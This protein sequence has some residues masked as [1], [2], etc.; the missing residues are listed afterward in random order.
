[1][2]NEEVINNVNAVVACKNRQFGSRDIVVIGGGAVGCETA[3]TIA[4]IG[5]LSADILKFLMVNEAESYE[6]LM[7]LLNR[8]VKN[9]TILELLKGIG[10]DI[11]SSTRWVVMK[12]IKR[13]GINVIDQVR[14]KRVNSNGVVVERDGQETLVP[15]DT[16]VLTV[17]SQSV[18]ELEGQLREKVAELHVIGD[19]AS[20]RKITEA[21]REGFDLAGQL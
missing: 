3:I 19:A 2:S 12:N 5:T 16:V 8:G 10:R 15:A 21:I 9:V 6:T 4:E 13:L 20:P 14:V 18:R 17:G 1:M 11:G 7:Q